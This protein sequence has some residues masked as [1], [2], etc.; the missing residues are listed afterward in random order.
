MTIMAD[1][2]FDIRENLALHGV[3]LN[4]PPSFIVK[5]NWMNTSSLKHEE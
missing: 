2:G 5:V 1:I 4:M 3:E